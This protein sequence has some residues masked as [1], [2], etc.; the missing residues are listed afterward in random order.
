MIKQIRFWWDMEDPNN[1]GWYAIVE[2]IEMGNREVIIDSQ[3][4]DFPADIIDYNIEDRDEVES[5]LRD[6]FPEYNIEQVETY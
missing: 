3:K 2:H 5:L 6:H 1:I 4:I